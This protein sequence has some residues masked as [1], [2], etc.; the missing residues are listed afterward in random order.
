MTSS[1]VTSITPGSSAIDSI[2]SSSSTDPETSAA[3]NGG[4]F[5]HTGSWLTPLA[6][7][8]SIATRT[9]SVGLTYKQAVE[10]RV[11]GLEHGADALIA[12]GEEA[13]VRH[14]VVVEHPARG[15]RDR[16]RD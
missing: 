2:S 6:R 4:V 12:L 8:R 1:T 15:S 5:L 13:E 9:V 7:I 14:P 11:S 3:A 16:N 10:G